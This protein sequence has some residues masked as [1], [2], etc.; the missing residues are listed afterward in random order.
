MTKLFKRFHYFRVRGPRFLLTI[1]QILAWADAHHAATGHWPISRSG[2]V[3][4][5]PVELTWVAIDQSL[6]SGF[7]GLPSGLTLAR[8]LH[9][10]RGVRYWFTAESLRR[11]NEKMRRNKAERINRPTLSVAQVVAWAEAHLVATGRWPTK[12]SGVV[13][14]VLGEIWASID[15]ALRKGRRGFPGASSLSRLLNDQRPQRRS[16]LTLEQILAWAEAHHAATGG[17]PTATSG[18]V[19][20]AP[21]E[22][23]SCIDSV[24]RRGRRGLPSGLSLWQLLGPDASHR[25]SLTLDQVVAWGEAHHASTGRWPR[26]SSGTIPGAPGETWEK[27]DENLHQ[28]QRGLPAGMSVAKLFAVRRVAPVT[29]QWTEKRSRSA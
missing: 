26:R 22:V 27:L 9:E 8:L 4:P 21:G 3:G 24:L 29:D 1:D 19:A 11:R 10:R 6:K 28:G 20:G 14:D 13:S 23:W 5:S 25:A 17:W 16:K 18:A 2:V 12:S 7:H 15:S